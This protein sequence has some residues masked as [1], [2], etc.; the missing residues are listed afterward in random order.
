MTVDA[1]LIRRHLDDRRL[2][3]LLVTARF[4]GGKSADDALALL[5]LLMT[6]ELLNKAQREADKEQ[7][8]QAP[9]ARPGIGPAGGG[10][11]GAVR[12]RRP[13]RAR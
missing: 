10:D 2:A 9:R 3:M 8:P 4:L 11:K 12:V 6:G 5:D 13:G 1:W 7:G